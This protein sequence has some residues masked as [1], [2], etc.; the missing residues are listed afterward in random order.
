MCSA[1]TEDRNHL[2]TCPDAKATKVFTTGLDRM[3]TI[4]VDLE[5]E[6][7]LHAAILGAL[8]LTRRRIIPHIHAFGL[9]DFS[10]GLTL[11]G[12]MQDK[13]RIGLINFFAGRW[14]VKWKEAQKRHYMRMNKRKSAKLWVVAILKKMMM[15]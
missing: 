4:M 2:F 7:T 8:K 3:K 14:G 11:P 1:P 6:P 5:T 10:D 9:T 12:I 15:I 13:H